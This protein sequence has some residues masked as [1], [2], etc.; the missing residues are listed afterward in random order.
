MTKEELEKAAR[1]W[2]STSFGKGGNFTEQDG[3]ML[4]RIN[5]GNKG[6]RA[7]AKWRIESVWHKPD[8]KPK[9]SV[10]ILALNKRNATIF[11][12]GGYIGDWSF[13]TKE[14]SIVKWAYVSDLL[15]EE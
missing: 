10:A 3:Y 1:E 14:Y 15:P 8:M 2:S 5:A 12:Q 13:I 4:A 6:F 9:E 7:G 11:Y